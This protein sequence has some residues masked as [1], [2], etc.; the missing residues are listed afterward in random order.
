MVYIIVPASPA[1]ALPG[2]DGIPIFLLLMKY[3]ALLFSLPGT[4]V[5]LAG[6]GRLAGPVI[7][8]LSGLLA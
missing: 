7:Y 2:S 5:L 6:E 1:F 8:M 4:L 3:R